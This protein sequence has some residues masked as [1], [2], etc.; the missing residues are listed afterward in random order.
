MINK[1]ENELE[2]EFSGFGLDCGGLVHDKRGRSTAY[3][4]AKGSK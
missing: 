4:A 2:S 1:K 3:H